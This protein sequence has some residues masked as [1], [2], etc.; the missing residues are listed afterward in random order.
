[1]KEYREGLIIPFSKAHLDDLNKDYEINKYWI[2]KDLQF[3]SEFS[4]NFI[5]QRFFGQEEFYVQEENP[6]SFFHQLRKDKEDEQSV[7]SIGE[8]LN[9]EFG[10]VFDNIF[11]DTIKSLIPNKEELKNSETGKQLE[12][13]MGEFLETGKFSSLITDIA[14]LGD[15][16]QNNPNQFNQLQKAIKT[17]TELDSNISNWKPAIE[18]LDK[19]LPDTKFQKS[20]STSVIEDV[21]RTYKKPVFFDL[22]VTCYNQLGL[23]GFRSEKLDEKNRFGNMIQDSFHSYYGFVA[24]L[25]IINEKNCFFKS[26]VL[27]DAFETKSQLV[28][29]FKIDDLEKFETKIDEALK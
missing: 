7:Q 9:T 10:D 15:E 29:M 28:K 26:E 25:F 6:I 1:M 16:F 24:D 2:D 11:G 13:I 21:G 17:D 5:I 27:F 22:Y 18:K 19:Y 8:E 23:Y 3:L 12:G 4:N 14:K 20:F